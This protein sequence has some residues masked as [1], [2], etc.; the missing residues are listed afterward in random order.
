MTWEKLKLLCWKNFTLQRRHPVAGLC[1]ILFPVMIALLFAYTK[2]MS[3]KRVDPAIIFE[4]SELLGLENCTITSQ[5]RPIEKIGFS[6]GDSVALRNI[7]EKVSSIEIESL[8]DSIKLDE[9]LK[10]EN[11]SYAGIEFDVDDDVR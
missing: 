11:R 2:S 3:P 7:L 10:T 1:E 5:Y 9:F 6:P 8:A 4:S